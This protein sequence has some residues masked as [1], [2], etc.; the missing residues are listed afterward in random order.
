[1]FAFSND[2]RDAFFCPAWLKPVFTQ[3]VSE[4]KKYQNPHIEMLP[5][6]EELWEDKIEHCMLR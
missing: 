4:A 3:Q 1:M 2:I 5:S 6:N